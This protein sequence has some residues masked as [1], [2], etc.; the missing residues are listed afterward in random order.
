MYEY[1]LA[2]SQIRAGLMLEHRRIQSYS[3]RFATIYNLDSVPCTR[4]FPPSM[5]I[6]TPFLADML[7]SIL[8]EKFVE[9][10]CSSHI[11]STWAS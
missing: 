4:R 6:S 1:D 7:V 5:G 3:L 9:I 11:V 8:Q 10:A 2:L